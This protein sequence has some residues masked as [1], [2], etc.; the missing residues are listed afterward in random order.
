MNN[1]KRFPFVERT[2]ALG[3]SNVLPFLPVVLT[4]GTKE[5]E[6]TALLDTG[7]SVNILPYDVGGAL[8]AVWE[9]QTVPI[10]LSGNLASTEARGL[11]VPAKIADYEPVL[12]SFAWTKSNDTPVVFGHT[13]FFEEFDVSFYRADLAFE[14][15]QRTK[16]F[17]A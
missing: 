4:Y 7:S 3:L 15:S 8:G 12:L 14:I 16:Q 1:S 11:V 2:N 13:N 9:A 5:V 6:L 17:I 10:L